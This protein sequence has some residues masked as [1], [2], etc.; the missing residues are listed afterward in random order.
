MHTPYYW[1]IIYSVFLLVGLHVLL[2]VDFL[3]SPKN[4][5][6]NRFRDTCIPLMLFSPLLPM[7][8]EKCVSLLISSYY[9]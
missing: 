3:G 5:T 2:G 4:R 9:G 7:P 1:S 6:K 8:R